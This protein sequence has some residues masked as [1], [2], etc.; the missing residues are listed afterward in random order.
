MCDHDLSVDA[1]SIYTSNYSTSNNPHH[2][3]S[4]Q[5]NPTY[6]FSGILRDLAT[7]F[8]AIPLEV[9]VRQGTLGTEGRS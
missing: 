2:G 4:K 7:F 1:T 9:E 6:L 3:I 5:S 8:L